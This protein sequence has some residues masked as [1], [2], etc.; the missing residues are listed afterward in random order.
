MTNR[1]G[2][3]ATRPVQ[4]QARRPQA[5]SHGSVKPAQGRAER[6]QGTDHTAAAEPV[7]SF[8]P[9]GT[10]GVSRLRADPRQAGLGKASGRPQLR[11]WQGLA[12]ANPINMHDY[13][14]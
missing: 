13:R 12:S 1:A 14:L 4:P 2:S 8:R 3:L 7:P 5:R 10:L 9:L 6:T 11:L